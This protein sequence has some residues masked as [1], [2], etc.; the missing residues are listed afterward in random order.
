MALSKRKEVS[1][2]RMKTLLVFRATARLIQR[3]LEVRLP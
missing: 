3:F 2:M 1:K